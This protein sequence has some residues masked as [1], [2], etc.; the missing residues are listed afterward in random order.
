MDI[1]VFEL[2]INVLDW[3]GEKITDRVENILR[4]AAGRNPQKPIFVISPFYCNDDY[5][6]IGKA[7]KW[8]NMIQETVKKTSYQNVTYV[9]GLDL[10]GNMSLISADEVHPDIYGIMG[11]AS[12]LYK[13]INEKNYYKCYELI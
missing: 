10:L 9:N 8:R 11:I 13:V 4:Q 3:D 6:K 5:L 2:G 1:A 7:D 12:K